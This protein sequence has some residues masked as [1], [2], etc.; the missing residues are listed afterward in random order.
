MSGALNPTSSRSTFV[1]LV[2]SV[3]RM[4]DRVKMVGF[5]SRVQENSISWDHVTQ[6]TEGD[7]E[8]LGLP[9]VSYSNPENGHFH[10][11]GIQ[12][13]FEDE[14]AFSSKDIQLRLMMCL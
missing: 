12:P 9:K 14:P 13:L 10:V 11:L 1:R 2:G 7:L 4:C 3:F 8:N 6:L 5:L